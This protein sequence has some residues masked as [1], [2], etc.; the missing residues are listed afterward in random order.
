MSDETMKYII[1]C[2][3]ENA[4]DVSNL[5]RNEFNDAKRLAYYEILNTIKS[6]LEV[7]DIDL[8]EYGLDFDI[9]N[10]L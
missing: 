9:E 8:K 3:L 5:P 7:N 2:I 10:I 4:E 6:Q 1:E